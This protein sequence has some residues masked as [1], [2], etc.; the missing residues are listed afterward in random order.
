MKKKSNPT[1][2]EALHSKLAAQI[3]SAQKTADAAKQAS[4]AAKAV[5]R[6]AKKDFK[7]ARRLAKIAK[8]VVKDLK[9][10]FADAPVTKPTPRKSVSSPRAAGKPVI[11]PPTMSP[12][13]KSDEVT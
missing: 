3:A 2:D 4:K 6:Q 5:F 12:P 8:K 11:L 7:E 1:S 9:A 13:L 10:E